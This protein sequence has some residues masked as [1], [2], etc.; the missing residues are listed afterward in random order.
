[1]VQLLFRALPNIPWYP[2]DKHDTHAHT[3]TNKTLLQNTTSLYNEPTYFHDTTPLPPPPPAPPLSHQH[4]RQQQQCLRY[5]YRHQPPPN[6]QPN[7]PVVATTVAG[8]HVYCKAEIVSWGQ[9]WSRDHIRT[10]Q[11]PDDTVAQWCHYNGTEEYC[12]D[13]L[14][15]NVWRI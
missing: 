15:A 11:S 3:H 4:D 7:K 8:D 5:H 12:W 1:M 9:S 14:K 10:F 6:N 13:E 2:T